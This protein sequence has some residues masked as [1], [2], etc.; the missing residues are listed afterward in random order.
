MKFISTRAQRNP[1][2]AGADNLIERAQCVNFEQAVLDCMPADGGLYVPAMFP[3]LSLQK[4]TA[5]GQMP[6]AERA[7]RILKLY[8]EDFTLPEISAATEAAYGA[9]RFD[10]PEIAP[11]HPLDDCTW[12]LELFHGPTLAFKDMEIGRAHV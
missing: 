1:G 5:L 4:I 7:M 9:D 10:H 8:L 2:I 6:Y 12:A 11:L 3:L